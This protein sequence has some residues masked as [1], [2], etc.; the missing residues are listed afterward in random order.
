MHAA[1]PLVRR[2]VALAVAD[3]TRQNLIASA[4][5]RLGREELAKRLNVPDHLLTA[6]MSGHATM[7][8]RKFLELADLLEQLGDSPAGK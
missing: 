4:A 3:T 1:Y 7:P 2:I 6:W 5:R 8:E